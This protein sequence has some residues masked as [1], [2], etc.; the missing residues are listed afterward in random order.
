MPPL[1]VIE[2]LDVLRDLAPRL[3]TGLV[4]TM[5]HELI[6]QRPPATLH[7]RV[8]MAIAPPT[9][10]WDDNESRACYQLSNVIEAAR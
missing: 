8:V 2:D 10:G 9:H 1:M 4:A 7:R 6:L 5:M 3:L